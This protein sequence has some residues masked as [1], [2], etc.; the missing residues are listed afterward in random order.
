MRGSPFVVSA[1]HGLSP[2]DLEEDSHAFHDVDDPKEGE[3]AAPGTVPDAKRSGDDEVQSA[4]SGR[5]RA[6]GDTAC[7]D[8][9]ASLFRGKPTVTDGPFAEAKE[10]L[11]AIG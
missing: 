1:G 2:L 6:A 4:T 3:S 10:V 7:P 11:G 5:W 9:C 8:G